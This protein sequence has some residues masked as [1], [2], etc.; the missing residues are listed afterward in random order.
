M[1]LR[2]LISI[3]T[4]I[5]TAHIANEFANSMRQPSRVTQGERMI[6]EHTCSRTTRTSTEARH[7]PKSKDIGLHPC[8]RQKNNELVN[9]TQRIATGETTGGRY[10]EKCTIRRDG[11]QRMPNHSSAAFAAERSDE[12]WS[13]EPSQQQHNCKTGG[14]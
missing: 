9:E 13:K 12:L 8:R 14:T 1:H 6:D 3:V 2:Q 11:A 5:A 4:L 10:A 7:A